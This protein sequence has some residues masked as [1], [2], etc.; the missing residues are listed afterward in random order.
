MKSELKSLEYFNTDLAEIE[1]AILTYELQIERMVR[2]SC[3]EMYFGQESRFRRWIRINS[4]RIDLVI[5][6]V[7]FSSVVLNIVLYILLGKIGSLI[8]SILTFICFLITFHFMNK[9]WK[10][11]KQAKVEIDKMVE[12]Y[13][14]TR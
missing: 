9:R 2:S 11:E 8:T 5:L 13:K 3:E 1:S 4:K 14:E 12:M 6:A 7:Q 10:L